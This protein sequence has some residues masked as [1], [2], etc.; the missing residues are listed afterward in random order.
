[1][2]HDL[3]PICR[4]LVSPGGTSESIALFCGRVDARTLREG[5]RGL[6]SEHEDIRVLLVAREETMTPARADQFRCPHHCPAMAGAESSATAGALGTGRAL[7]VAATS[8][9]GSAPD[10]AAH[11]STGAQTVPTVP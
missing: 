1:M 11:G 3:V 9:D 10:P 5:I 2:L 4:Y 8:Q 6:A 7:K